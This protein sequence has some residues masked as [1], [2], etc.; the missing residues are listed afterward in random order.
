MAPSRTGARIEPSR[1]GLIDLGRR[2]AAIANRRAAVGLAVGVV[3]DGS[4]TSY[5]AHGVADVVGRT[6]LVKRPWPWVRR[7]WARR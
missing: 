2:V 4:L 1:A 7:R 3:A 5:S 6:P